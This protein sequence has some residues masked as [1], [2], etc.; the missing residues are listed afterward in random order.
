MGS[1]F[2]T[3]DGV[4]FHNPGFYSA[5]DR[6]PRFFFNPRDK[7]VVY[8]T[9]D[10]VVK[11]SHNKGE[12][13]EYFF[14]QPDNIAGVTNDG[15]FV[16]DIVKPIGVFARSDVI[17]VYVHP[18]DRNTV[19][20]FSRGGGA[21]YGFGSYSDNQNISQNAPAIYVTRNGGLSWSIFNDA[22]PGGRITVG[23]SGKFS[24][25]IGGDGISGL[26]YPYANMVVFKNELHLLSNHG[27]FIL[28]PATGA[29]IDYKIYRNSAGHFAISKDGE[30][31]S[32]YQVISRDDVADPY[33]NIPAHRNFPGY[34]SMGIAPHSTLYPRHIFKTTDGGNTFELVSGN[35][36]AELVYTF[37]GKNRKLPDGITSSNNTRGYVNLKGISLSED[38]TLFV[39]FSAIGRDSNNADLSNGWESGV[40]KTTNDGKTWEWVQMGRHV[41]ASIQ[42]P[43]GTSPTHI[44]K[45]PRHSQSG[46]SVAK[47]D[48]NHIITTEGLDAN[49]TRDGGRTWQTMSS[50]RIIQ[51]GKSSFTTSGIEPAGQMTL[52]VN[53]F[54]RQHHFAGWTDIGAWESID[55]GK[56]WTRR[57][58]MAGT[59]YIYNCSAV[60]FD[61]HNEGVVLVADPARQRD[62][63]RGGAYNTGYSTVLDDIR[64]VP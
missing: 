21:G 20:V 48:T 34:A 4:N 24:G 35:F 10:N 37:H 39:V 25:H 52:A 43:T 7:N 40:A 16:R 46:M 8:A 63:M 6:L 29:L 32:A 64:P 3:K 33:N 28:N 62:A 55:G 22:I 31:L 56:S 27:Y 18:S 30:T 44:G 47:F 36:A 11:V 2:Y 61:L 49:E 53:P 17:S 13:W 59:G 9:T 45:D 12:T 26:R 23:D 50:H 5:I 41:L 51:D 38:G 57:T 15:A 60:A 14:P 42:F 58:D 1:V 54:N 19:F